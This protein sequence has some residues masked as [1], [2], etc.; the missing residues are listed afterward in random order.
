MIEIGP[1]LQQ[2][3]LVVVGVAV[4]VYRYEMTRLEWIL[5]IIAMLYFLVALVGKLSA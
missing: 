2:L 4:L 1:N 5:A 3:L